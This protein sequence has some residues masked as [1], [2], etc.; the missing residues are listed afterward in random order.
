MHQDHGQCILQI[1]TCVH[2]KTGIDSSFLSNNVFCVLVPSERAHI[3]FLE[4]ALKVELTAAKTLGLPTITYFHTFTLLPS[5]ALG[6]W[7]CSHRR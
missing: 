5:R 1:L 2:H 4:Q 6:R 3:L 7:F